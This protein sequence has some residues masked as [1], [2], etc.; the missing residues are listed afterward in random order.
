MARSKGDTWQETM[1]VNYM[2]E[3]PKVGRLAEYLGVD[4]WS[5][6]EWDFPLRS[7]EALAEPVHPTAPGSQLPWKEDQSVEHPGSWLQPQIRFLSSERKMLSC[8]SKTTLGDDFN[9]PK[10]KLNPPYEMYSFPSCFFWL[11]SS[12]FW[13]VTDPWPQGLLSN[14]VRGQKSSKMKMETE[15]LIGS[16]PEG[17]TQLTSLQDRLVSPQK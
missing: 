6:I 17:G 16:L 15:E 13:L 14:P 11:R 10:W 3:W 5:W 9:L 7:L 12:V 4:G 8:V 1:N 2:R